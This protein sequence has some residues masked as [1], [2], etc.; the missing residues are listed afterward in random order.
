MS[1]GKGLESRSVM[2]VE[3]PIMINDGDTSPFL[4]LIAVFSQKFQ[5]HSDK[6]PTT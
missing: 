4:Q 3:V 5:A 6:I 2:T 1:H